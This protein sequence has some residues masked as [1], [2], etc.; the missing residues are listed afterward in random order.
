M[1]PAPFGGSAGGLPAPSGEAAADPG[2]GET[3]WEDTLGGKFALAL[4]K[5]EG[6]LYAV[7][8]SHPH[9]H[10]KGSSWVMRQ[11]YDRQHPRCLWGPETW[12]RRSLNFN[13][14]FGCGP[15]GQC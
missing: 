2:E 1:A 4:E 14:I 11:R 10:G 9:A 5:L 13:G 7:F 6:L 3:N 8:G 12:E 15:E